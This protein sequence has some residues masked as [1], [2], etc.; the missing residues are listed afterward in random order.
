[1]ERANRLIVWVFYAAFALLGVALA[2]EGRFFLLAVSYGAAALGF[3]AV[4]ALR[5]IVAAPRPYQNGGP[6][7][8]IA[9][10]GENDS[11]PSRHCFSA[12]II[13]FLWGLAGFWGICTCLGALA[14]LLAI[15]RVQGGVHYPRDVLGALA[16]AALFAGLALLL[17]VL[18]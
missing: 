3:G 2:A 12:F 13:T 5:R 17:N 7:A 14:V 10:E 16:C 18:F 6:A 1:M 9:R 4:T 15:L 11:F 8:A